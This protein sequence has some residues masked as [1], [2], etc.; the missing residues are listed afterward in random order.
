MSDTPLISVCMPAYR[1]ED[2]VGNAIESILG[3]TFGDFELLINDDCSPDRTFEVIQSFKDPRIHAVRNSHRS[4][5]SITL[6]S[7][8]RRA[9]GRY[10]A[11]CSSDDRWLPEKLAVQLA[12]LESHPQTDAVFFRPW[13]ID[14]EGRRQPD[15]AH[16]LGEDFGGETYG[17]R[18][19]LVRM[20][21]QGNCL[22]AITPMFRM[23][24]V[25]DTGEFNPL[26]LQ[27]QDFDY[28]VRFLAR[29]D[30][31]ML[32]E[33]L[34]EYRVASTGASLSSGTVET[35]ARSAHELCE[36]LRHYA[37]GEP[38]DALASLPL[39]GPTMLPWRP[40]T[41]SR[42]YRLAEH[43]MHVAVE[44]EHH[45]L[46]HY[47]FAL[48]CLKAHAAGPDG[49]LG[50]EGETRLLPLP[51]FEV[52]GSSLASNYFLGTER[53]DVMKRTAMKPDPGAAQ[54]EVPPADTPPGQGWW[55]R[56]RKGFR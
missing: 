6:N 49:M 5:P 27:L 29:H 22:C 38:A 36:V 13:L 14:S 20:F 45:S 19:W 4:G 42:A 16:I 44:I 51:Y 28:W 15:E 43:A 9:R 52:T 37:D 18:E 35:F 53:S 2:H 12:W 55:E 41:P 46:A 40:R 17:R 1:H 47:L 26:M 31:R 34:A 21:F 10:L 23:D 8:M 3:Q 39:Q 48:D 50:A 25:R 11:L 24:A 7:A 30:M 56:L 32:P 33:R 54:A